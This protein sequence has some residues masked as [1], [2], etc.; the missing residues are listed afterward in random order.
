MENNRSLPVGVIGLAVGFV[1]I[2]I[3]L[4]VVIIKSTSSSGG[5]VPVDF[6][7]QDVTSA[8]VVYNFFAPIKSVDS[9]TTQKQMV[10]DTQNDTIPSFTVT[11]STQVYNVTQNASKKRQFV[12]VGKSFLKAGQKV[13]VIAA[14]TPKTQKWITQYIYI[15]SYNP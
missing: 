11:N 10:L 13:A 14:Y 15:Q 7:S 12:K 6:A 9:N 4:F 2:V 5:S 3:I 1:V 8:T